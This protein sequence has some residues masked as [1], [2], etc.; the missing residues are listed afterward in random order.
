MFQLRSV[1]DTVVEATPQKPVTQ[2]PSSSTGA[3]LNDDWEDPNDLTRYGIY[4]DDDYD[5]SQHL[6]DPNDNKWSEETVEMYTISEHQKVSLKYNDT[7]M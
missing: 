1:E 3:A 5:Y 4:F 7:Y 2:A 6:R